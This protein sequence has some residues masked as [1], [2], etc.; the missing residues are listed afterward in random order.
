MGIVLGEN[1][2]YLVRSRL[3]G[4]AMQNNYVSFDLF[5]DDVIAKRK[6]AITQ[7]ALEQMTTNE[8]SW[9]RDTYP[10]TLLEQAILP[11]LVKQS[12]RLRI[13]SAAC[14][15]GQEAYSIA[16][17]ILEYQRTRGA[18]FAGGVEIIGTDVA[19]KMVEAS[20][21]AVYNEATL[22]RGFPQHLF[23]RYVTQLASDEFKVN[24]S[25]TDLASF[26][27]FNLLNDFTPMGKFDIIFCRN[28]LIYFEE[29]QKQAILKKF[30]ACLPVGGVLFLGAAET[31]SGV[32]DTFAM[33]HGSKGLYYTKR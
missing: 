30:A 23:D 15:T 12:K 20:T 21:K 13:W 16:M 10:F 5:L 33:Q 25:V 19:N 3:S 6:P 8:T 28:V 24:S 22:G 29:A 1:K 26:K 4:L 31:I 17:C 9:F 18:R 32:E 2:Q 14:S 27:Q 7:Q 11:N